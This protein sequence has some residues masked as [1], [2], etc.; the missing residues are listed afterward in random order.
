MLNSLC[1]KNSGFGGVYIL[2]HWT[3]NMGHTHLCPLY[4]P[5]Q[6]KFLQLLSGDWGQTLC[7]F[8]DF[9]EALT[10]AIL[11]NTQWE[12]LRAWTWAMLPYSAPNPPSF[13]PYSVPIV[14]PMLAPQQLGHCS[15][16]HCQQSGDST[17][18]GLLEKQPVLRAL[19]AGTNNCKY[20]ADTQFLKSSS[21]WHRGVKPIVRRLV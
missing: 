21:C 1:E 20:S 13:H 14:V 8:P 12:F 17:A 15:P 2:R 7:S 4:L 3:L 18:L 6:E 5:G 19:S 9:T 16:N 11:W 10:C